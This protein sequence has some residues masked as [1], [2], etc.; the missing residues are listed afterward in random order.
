M[1]LF[2][3]FVSPPVKT[4]SNSARD[5]SVFFSIYKYGKIWLKKRVKINTFLNRTC[6]NYYRSFGYMCVITWAL[7]VSWLCG[8]YYSRIFCQELNTRSCKKPLH[9]RRDYNTRALPA[10]NN[11]SCVK[12]NLGKLMMHRSAFNN[13]HIIM[14]LYHIIYLYAVLMKIGELKVQK[15]YE[16]HFV[17]IIIIF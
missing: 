16:L 1:K 13:H 9:I 11:N 5:W 8:Y 3:R 6:Y 7:R 2:S 17:E 12:E 4:R 15:F 10:R 14:I